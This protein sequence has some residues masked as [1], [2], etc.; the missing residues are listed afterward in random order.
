MT[1]ASTF[2]KYR[3]VAELGHGGMADVY[4]A[5]QQGPVGFNKLVVVKRLRPNLADDPEFIAMLVDEARLAARL[6]HPNIVQT[7][8]IDAV[9]NRYFIAMEYLDGQPMHKISYRARTKPSGLTSN[10]QYAILCDV[11]GGL[12]HAHDLT[13]FDGTPLCV[14][15]R[16]VSPHNIFVTYDGQVKVVDFG[17]AKAVGRAAEET[18]AG[19]IKGKVAYMAPEQAMGSDLDPRADVFAVGIMLWEVST[20]TRLW[21]G[22]DDMQVLRRLISGEFGRSP[23]AIDPTIPEEIDRIC[24]LALAPNVEERYASAA[25]MQADLEK[26]LSTVGRPTTRDIGKVIT[27]LFEDKRRETR[28]IIAELKTLPAGEFKPIVFAPDSFESLNGASDAGSGPALSAPDIQPL[29]LHDGSYGSRYAGGVSGVARPPDRGR[30]GQLIMALT[31]TAALV[32]AIAGV[33][34]VRSAPKN[35]ATNTTA[36][37]VVTTAPPLP[38]MMPAPT[39]APPLATASASAHDDRSATAVPVATSAQ[40]PLVARPNPRVSV[41]AGAS[42]TAAVP[43]TPPNTAVP[44]DGLSTRK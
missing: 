4:L 15:H 8:E 43:T 22:L 11:L 20:G 5:I 40:R 21:K 24:Q 42:A 17:I 32:V 13:D 3:L 12:Q 29:D 38:T 14:V 9:G 28:E 30:L 41:G 1:D 44:D 33:V 37:W 27:D 36:P 6:N 2:G 23:R 16:D 10:M 39:V 26:Y 31:G 7:N 18:R 34:A 25:A 19:V 35:K